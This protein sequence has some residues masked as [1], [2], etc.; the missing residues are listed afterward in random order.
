MAS[1]GKIAPPPGSIPTSP[2]ARLVE[3]GRQIAHP[4]LCDA[5]DHLNT[6]HYQ[7]FFDD[8]AQHL[9]AQCGFAG[10][11]EAGRLGV[12]D[13]SCAM[14]YLAE[15]RPGTLLVLHSGFKRIGG[16]SFTSVHEMRSIDGTH[17]FAT[18]E[19]I[20]IFFDLEV[21]RSA[22]MPEAFRA[23][24]EALLV[25]EKDGEAVRA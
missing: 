15:V 7:G 8:A 17:L 13:A 3:T 19:I 22:A 14:T 9:L 20:S 10:A 11:A 18:C 5:N 16:K 2:V 12:V 1:R 24:A 23:A 21:R 6:R 25:V 4:W